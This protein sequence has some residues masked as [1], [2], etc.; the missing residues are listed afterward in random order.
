MKLQSK[1]KKYLQSEQY[2][3]VNAD[4]SDEMKYLTSEDRHGRV[5]RDVSRTARRE[6]VADAIAKRH[7][8]TYTNTRTH[9]LHWKCQIFCHCSPTFESQ[10]EN[11]KQL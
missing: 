8:Y 10:N 4:E 7:A 2:V 5:L 11:D 6:K 3:N 9:R 1:E